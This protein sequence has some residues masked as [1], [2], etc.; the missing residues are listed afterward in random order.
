[1]MHD[2]EKRPAEVPRGWLCPLQ[3]HHHLSSMNTIWASKETSL[4]CLCDPGILSLWTLWSVWSL[5]VS[6]L[7]QWHDS[8]LVYLAG[9]TNLE[10]PAICLNFLQWTENLCVPPGRLTLDGSSSNSNCFIL[11]CHVG[12]TFWSVQDPQS[13]SH[14]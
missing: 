6:Q 1:M 4:R 11:S 13:C 12:T 3:N 2:C 14:P 5:L 7:G 9:G 10:R 8:T